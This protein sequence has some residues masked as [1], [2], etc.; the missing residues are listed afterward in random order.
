MFCGSNQAWSTFDPNGWSDPTQRWQVAIDYN[1][2]TTSEPE[3]TF[4]L[5]RGGGS[6]RNKKKERRYVLEMDDKMYQVSS[7]EEAR[8]ILQS[9]PK[10]QKKNKTLKLPK[11]TIELGEVSRVKVKNVPLV[12][13]LTMNVPLDLIEDA[14]QRIEDDEEEALLLLLH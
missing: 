5:P 1:A 13:A 12:K 4:T 6:N 2:V 8:A 11:L 7:L 3:P 9:Q 14:I 10:P